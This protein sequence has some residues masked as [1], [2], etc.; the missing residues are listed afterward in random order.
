MEK[1]KRRVSGR[2]VAAIAIVL[3]ASLVAVARVMGASWQQIVWGT[4]GCLASALVLEFFAWLTTGG[5]L[6][7]EK[8]PP[9]DVDQRTDRPE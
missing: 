6:R 5:P 8:T 1:P 2:I 9:Q 4:F 7:L 3:V